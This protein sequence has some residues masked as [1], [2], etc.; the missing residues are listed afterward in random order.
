MPERTYMDVWNRFN[1][2]QSAL[3]LAKPNDRSF[4]DRAYAVT[5]TE[6]EKAMAY[7][8]VF[9]MQPLMVEEAVKENEKG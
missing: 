2:L 3:Q 4:V 7:F 9:V 5:L 1:E 8:H 6:V